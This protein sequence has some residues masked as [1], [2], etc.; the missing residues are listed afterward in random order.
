MRKL[1]FFTKII[2]LLF[3]FYIPSKGKSKIEE[4]IVRVRSGNKYSTGF[5]WKNGSTIIAT[6]HSLSSKNDIKIQFPNH[7]DWIDVTLVKIHKSSDLVMLNL[8]SIT[9]SKFLTENYVS[10]PPFQT[11]CY[12]VGYNLGGTNYISRN[13]I[14]G[15]SENNS[16]SSILPRKFHNDIQNWGLLSKETEVVYI[17][18]QLL[19]GFSGAPIVD[20][21]GT[22]IGI[23]DGGL[24]NGAS[25][26]SWCI[27]SKYLNVLE[28]SKEEI[29]IPNQKTVNSLFA[30]EEQDG[31]ERF[32]F[33]IYNGFKFN[34]IKTRTFSDLN[35]TGKYSSIDSIGLVQLLN[36]FNLC[37]YMSFKYD[38]YVEEKTGATI[39]VPTDIKLK[40]KRN[41]IYYE[42]DIIKL[43]FSL[44]KSNNI[45]RSS[46][47]FEESIMPRLESNWIKDTNWT[48][49]KHYFGPN[50][51]I[52][53][54]K[55]FFGNNNTSY[56]FE[57][58]TAKDVYFLGAAAHRD[59]SKISTVELDLW[60][61]FAI[62]IQLITFSN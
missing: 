11:P 13:F 10:K 54:R 45:Q 20:L 50:N 9:T 32:D 21:K 25:G 43:T 49:Q 37:N 15:L 12:T 56:L 5:F 36:S 46:I 58:L 24:E 8:K 61:K 55:A 59:N 53:R 38:I 47:L 26:I 40:V 2:F 7:S 57:A 19:H 3:F 51:T 30:A 29:V 62:A 33:F 17:D 31:I 6:L 60:A 34:K 14:V 39:V 52:V 44:V 16:L 22:L 4:C 1:I 23:A 27:S 41:K 42:S 18:G 35:N 28:N 48:Y